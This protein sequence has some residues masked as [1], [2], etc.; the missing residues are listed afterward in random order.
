M[1]DKL[2][3]L[4]YACRQGKFIWIFL[5]STH[6]V[7]AISC[8]IMSLVIFIWLKRL[9]FTLW[10]LL[11]IIFFLL[12]T[13]TICRSQTVRAHPIRGVW[14]STHSNTVHHPLSVPVRPI[15]LPTRCQ[16]AALPCIIRAAVKWPCCVCVC[17]I[18]TQK[19]SVQRLMRVCV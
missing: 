8:I 17:A 1:R 18:R 12:E 9:F 3:I 19:L 7:A 2:K 10:T 14:L 5:A 4:N 6:K 16:R 15:G 11:R 13:A